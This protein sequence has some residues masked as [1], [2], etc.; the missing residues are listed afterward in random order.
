MREFYYRNRLKIDLLLFFA[1]IAIVFYLFFTVFFVMLS[2]FFFGM[3]IALL[4][5]PV[6]RLFEKR[7]K[8]KRWIASL[9]CLIIFLG[10]M[11]SLGVWLVNTLVRQV[12]AFAESAPIHAEEIANR[13]EE[14]NLWL[15][16]ITE[17]FMPEGWRVPDIEEMAVAAVGFVFSGG[18]GDQGIQ[19]VTNVVDFFI[20]L[21][22]TFVSAYFFMS[23]RAR[24]FR[25][26]KKACPQW[27][28][29]QMNM[30]KSGLKRAMGG[31]F[32]AQGILMA[33]VGIISIT[34]LLIMGNEYAL[35]LGLLFA[36]LDF[37]PILGPTLIIAPWAIL[38]VIMGNF[39]QAIGLG[40][41]FGVITI[42]RQVLQPK[43]MGDQMGAHP[44][45]S[46]MSIFIGFRIFGILG[47]IVG[48]TLLMIFIAI[49]DANKK[50]N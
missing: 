48:P 18:F 24:I 42:S 3:I 1:L 4:L 7:M 25:T 32:R 28:V 34:G 46:L 36:V 50:I 16:D 11:G 27:L 44:L 13:L 37:L 30:T 45:A 47:F 17:S 9:L 8:I 15:A 21:V 38:S 19:V 35:L 6:V 43:I 40:I 10:A 23:D 49:Q 22:L 29:E 2:P 5:E 31:Y 39:H 26:M 33:M 20:N 14:A 41:I 12:A